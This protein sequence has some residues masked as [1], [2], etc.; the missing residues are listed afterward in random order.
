MRLKED[1]DVQQI[2]TLAEAAA[3]IRVSEKTL[4]EMARTGRIPSK[5]VGREW[6]FLRTGL[7]AWLVAESGHTAKTG[8]AD[9]AADGSGLVS[10]PV[11]DA[12]FELLPSSGFRD[13]G[14]SENHDR[15]LHRWVP[16]IAGFSGSFVAGVLDAVRSHGRKMHVLDPFAGVGTNAHRSAQAR[17]RRRR[18]RN[19]SVC[20]S[21]MQGQILRD[22]IRPRHTGNG[23]CPLRGTR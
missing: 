10:E 11:T 1:T 17:R 4:G 21:G 6:R 8:F 9:R 7:E 15:A 3:F 5:K 14:F 19:Q 22:G 20:I 23:H 2:L 18:L 13:T 16:W 12:Q